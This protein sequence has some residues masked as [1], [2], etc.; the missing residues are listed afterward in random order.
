VPLLILLAIALIGGSVG[1]SWYQDSLDYVTT[2]NAQVAGRLL[3]VGGL[4]AGRVADVRFDVGQRV[5]RDQIVARLYAPVPVGVTA[6]GQPRLEYRTTEDALVEVTAPLDGV[7]V[8]RSANPGDTL[9]AGQ[10]ILTLV[11]P[12][13]LWINANVEET[14]IR[15]V[16]AGQPVVV[17]VDALGRDIAGRVSAITPAS[18]GTFSLLPQSNLSGSFTKQTQLVPVK[19][20]L[21]G[22]DAGLTIG[23]SVRVKIRVRD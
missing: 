12:T 18:A 20:E 14:K 6:S 13:R 23:T 19:I 5:A 9:P 16:Q 3:Q 8:A 7:V 2:D 21:P 17:Y 22:G 4:T 15:R 10:P 11:D 1:W